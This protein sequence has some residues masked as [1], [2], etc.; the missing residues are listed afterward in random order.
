MRLSRVYAFSRAALSLAFGATAGAQCDADEKDKPAASLLGS[1]VPSVSFSWPVNQSATIYQDYSAYDQVPQWF[2]NKYHTGIDLG[3]AN[4][5]VLAAASGFVQSVR[6]DDGSGT[7]WGNAIMLRH[8]G[9]L[10]SLYAHLASFSGTLTP[11]QYVSSGTQLGVMG[12]TGAATGV[13]LHFEIKPDSMR[14]PGY[15]EDVPD[16]Y[17]Y[18]DPRV[19]IYPIGDTPITPVVVKVVTS[20]YVNVRSG[21]AMTGQAAT[22]YAKLT[23]ILT[24]QSFVAFARSGDWRKIYMPNA[25]GP[26][27]GWAVSTWGGDVY[28]SE[29]P[30]IGQVEVRD[31]GASGLRVRRDAGTDPIETVK[32]RDKATTM[33]VWDG[34]RFAALD[35]KIGTD[36]FMWYKINLPRVAD[37]GE[38]WVREDYVDHFP[39]SDNLPVVNALNVNPDSLTLGGSFTISYSVSDDVGLNQTELWRTSDIGGAPNPDWPNNPIDWSPLSGERSYSGSFQD[40]SHPSPGIY[41]YGL[42][43]LDDHDWN[44]EQN[45]RTGGLPGD[46]GPIRVQVL[47]PTGSLTVTIN[48]AE[49]RSSARWRLTSGPDTTWKHSGETISNIPFGGPYTLTFTDVSGWRKPDDTSV[50]IAEGANSESGIYRDIAPPV[51]SLLGDNPM[52]LDVGA[53]Y[54]EPGYTA[55]DNCDGDIT[56][57]VLVAGS[58]NNTVLGSYT[59]HYNVGDSSGNPAEEKTRT[60]RVVDTTAPA[61]TLLGDNPMTLEVGTPYTEPG[62][63]AT[64]NYDGDITANVVVTGSVDHTTLGTYT[65]R[66]NVTDSSGNPAEEKTRTVSVVETR[67]FELLEVKIPAEGTIQLTW[68]SRPGATYT[69]W[70]CGDLCA[71]PWTEEATIASQGDSTEW[72]DPEAACTCKF[73]RIELK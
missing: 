46:F 31:T 16:G 59:L 44:D 50:S 23:E 62:S 47:P 17:G 51:I 40:S 38:G 71:G 48:P 41:W 13:H 63:I 58:V 25:K 35:K 57:N 73:Y 7:G 33:K 61:I 9:G 67:P 26:V 39:P 55:T 69:V 52:V 53:P 34:Q 27:S 1:D 22:T 15:T 18:T 19:H 37:Q 28:L 12:D 43:V 11:E 20:P 60:V 32:A 3:T 65:L 45:S 36:G 6:Y 72:T 4:R 2:P 70:S 29:D 66:Y 30:A 10:Y 54:G 21:P 8:D 56:A 68:T 49:V 5:S 64:D 24:G 14:G 42:H